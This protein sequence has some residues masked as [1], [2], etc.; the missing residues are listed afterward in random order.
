M[1]DIVVAGSLRTRAEAWNWFDGSADDSYVYPG[2]IARIGLSQKKTRVDWQIELAVPFVLGLPDDA[3]APGAQGQLGLG[4][5]YFA[6]NSNRRNVAELFVKQASVRIT[7]LGGVAGQS[8]KAG[9]MEFIDGTEVTPRHATL[10]AVKRDRIAHRLLGNF[11]FS[12]V[13]RSFDGAQWVLN[14]SALNATAFAGRPTRGVFVVDGWSGLDINVF[15]GALTGQTGTDADA[16]E[17]RVFGL[18]Y[19]DRRDGVVKTDNRSPAVRTADRERI[20]IG[21]FGGHYLR[22]LPA[23]AGAV[24]LLAWGAVQLGS[25]GALD[26]RAGTFAVEAGWQPE[27]LEAVAP[28]FRGGYNYGSGD[29]DPNDGRHGTFFQVLPTPRLYARFPFFNMMNTGD[30]FGEVILRPSRRLSVRGDVHVIRLASK[31]DL[32]YAGGGAFQSSTFGFIGR[33]SNGRTGLAT[34]SD[35]SGDYRVNGYAS[36]AVYYGRAAGR[37]VTDAIYANGAD[38]DFGYVEMTLRF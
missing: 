30:A 21:T 8:L 38:A 29:G 22:T 10:A 27:A 20:D 19:F 2:S 36:V 26:Q 14:R 6:A 35:V 34:L 7:D 37:S 33:P 28:W 17:W 9:R 23:A 3:V 1:G 32:W 24:D 13:G 4:A 15:Y 16:G 25:W 18:G 31:H 5:T 12:H 11:A